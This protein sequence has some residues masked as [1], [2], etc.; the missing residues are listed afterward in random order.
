LETVVIHE[1][2]H[3]LGLGHRDDAA[4]VMHPTLTA[5]AATRALVEADLNVPDGDDGDACGL[6]AAA[7]APRAGGGDPGGRGGAAGA[8]GA[9]ADAVADRTGRVG[10]ITSSRSVL[11]FANPHP[12]ADGAGAPIVRIAAFDADPVASA[13][14]VTTWTRTDSYSDP[15][16]SRL[17]AGDGL[18]AGR[19]L[20]SDPDREDLPAAALTRRES[21]QGF[22]VNRDGNNGLKRG[23][24]DLPTDVPARPGDVDRLDPP[25]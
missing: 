16:G 4:S 3:V 21:G 19:R 24:K 9:P 8:F 22:P 14:V 7:P 11:V 20:T 23:V 2:G 17:R 12:V 18:S 25:T 15:R 6:H 1:L 13:T 5:G 10:P